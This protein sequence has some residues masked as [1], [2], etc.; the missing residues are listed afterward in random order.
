[1][2]EESAKEVVAFV[3]T[4]GTVVD[5]LT[6][7]PPVTVRD[8]DDAVILGEALAAGADLLV[9]GDRDLLELEH[10]SLRIVDPRGFWA[11]TRRGL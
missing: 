10:V 6:S 3:R 9:T 7:A 1:M 4:H 2:P 5:P 11:L 8:A